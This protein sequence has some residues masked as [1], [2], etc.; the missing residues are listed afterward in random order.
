MLPAVEPVAPPPSYG[1]GP[2]SVDPNSNLQPLPPVA[3]LPAYTPSQQ[4]TNA[5]GVTQEPKESY[6]EL[7]RKG[8]L[9]AALT[10]VSDVRY[11]K[12]MPTFLEGQ[13]LKGRV[14][15]TLDKPDAILSV[16]ISV[17][18]PSV[19]SARRNFSISQTSVI[20]CRFTASLSRARTEANN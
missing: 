14:R 10:M 20:V 7:K 11:S 1:G 18:S 2:P 8:R 13:P 16:I 3:E 19:E 5:R 6:Y 17:S 9:F 4:P 15:L 12:H